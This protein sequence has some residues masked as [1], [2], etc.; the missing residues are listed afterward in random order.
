M[1]RTWIVLIAALICNHAEAAGCDDFRTSITTCA[2]QDHAHRIVCVRNVMK[3][4][5]TGG[6]CLADQGK[7]ARDA[8][9]TSAWAAIKQEA[10]ALRTA[11]CV[12]NG[13]DECAEKP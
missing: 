6:A 9:A 11:R 5:Q 3:A 8:I 12:R 7:A 1:A 13:I 2:A 10:T 4:E